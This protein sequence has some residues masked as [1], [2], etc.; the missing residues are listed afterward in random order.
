VKRRIRVTAGRL[1][2]ADRVAR[3]APSITLSMFGG[4]KPKKPG[5]HM[6]E[7]SAL[8]ATATTHL[9]IEQER[10]RLRSPHPPM[11]LMLVLQF[12]KGD[13]ARALR[14]A[15]LLADI[16]PARR[17]DVILVFARRFDVPLSPTIWKAG[18]HCGHKFTIMHIQSKRRAHGHP[19]G[20]Y[21]L[22]AGAAEQLY[23]WY[24]TKGGMLSQFHSAFFF[25][26]DLAPTV[27]D[28]IDRLK[29]AHIQT[30]QQQKR[31]TG[32][33]TGRPNADHRV[34]WDHVN[35]NL[36]MHW[37]CWGDHKSLHRCPPG[38]PWDLYHAQV[39]MSEVGTYQPILNLSGSQKFSRDVYLTLGQSWCCVVNVKDDS[40]QR[41]AREYLVP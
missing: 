5:R 23:E 12:W 40:A 28:W 21:G 31:I 22:W 3:I 24:S 27:K 32:A 25:E 11:P 38:I 6:I 10:A 30:L 36:V 2:K 39:L 37:S 16:E 26:P 41:F 18:L 8:G 9:L 14:L 29:K 4:G 19:D 20:C 33:I 15:R 7:Q 35:G 34:D 17:D 13:Q 1:T